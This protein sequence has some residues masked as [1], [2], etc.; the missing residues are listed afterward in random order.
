M[1]NDPTAAE[2]FVAGFA[3]ASVGDTTPRTL[4]A[5]CDDGSGQMCSFENSTCNGSPKPC[6]GRGPLFANL[7][8]GISD[9][10][11]TGQK[12]YSAALDLYNNFDS[13]EAV[14]TDG[15]VKAFH[16]F[17]DMRYFKFELPNGTTV[18]TCPAALG[19]S[20]AAGTSDFPGPF[21]FTQGD[22]GKPN[23]N[24][25]WQVVS[26]LIKSPSPEQK[27]CQQPKP[28]LLDAGELDT[29]YPWAPNIIDVQ[30][31][32][33]GNLVIIV[34]PSEVTT[35]AG[36][37]WKEAVAEA[38][39]S[40]NIVSQDPI[41][42]LGSPGNSYAHYVT[43]PEEFGI[44]RY[45]GASCLY[46]QWELPAYINLTAS[47]VRY[48]S[49]QS[50]TGPDQG[51]LPPDNRNKSLDFISPVV[52]DNPPIGKS[53]GD[54]LTQPS[55]SYKVGAVISATFVGADPR[56]NLRLE[57]TYTAVEQLQG[58]TWV[59]IRDDSDW[60]LTMTWKRLNEL[61]GSSQV[62]IAWE[63]ASDDVKPG[64]YRL[65]YYG[66]HKPVVGSISAFEA[67]SSNFTIS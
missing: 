18:Q 64:T 60:F 67:I 49:A 44:Q 50:T 51:P 48:L 42:V 1:A 55:S 17:Q 26:A 23:A 30:L 15:S 20:F 36:R 54:V 9:C 61:I 3:Q 29:P 38:V 5:F 25:L 4:G 37:R 21:D 59:R 34:S 66:D 12:Q 2:G 7:D 63:T 62:E 8:L 53:F 19:Y 45:E 58:N 6:N 28:I 10:Y 13:A 65:H 40:Q 22:S 52:Y 27:E 39:V 43:T 24:P 31:L 33:V 56:N 46:G 47:N 32:R 57:E 11:L 35:M 14:L 16:F 41:V